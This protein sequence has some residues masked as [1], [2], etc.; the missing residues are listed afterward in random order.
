MAVRAD[1]QTALRRQGTRRWERLLRQNVDE[2]IQLSRGAE[3]KLGCVKLYVQEGVSLV[4]N[5]RGHRRIERI[6]AIH[7]AVNPERDGRST[8]VRLIAE[9]IFRAHGSTGAP[10]MSA[11]QSRQSFT[12][13]C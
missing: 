10:S 9:V 3:P 11:M 7:R 6:R 8:P 13:L 12:D 1:R 2:M 5:G 4:R